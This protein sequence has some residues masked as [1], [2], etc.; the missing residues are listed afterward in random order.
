MLKSLIFPFCIELVSFIPFDAMLRL[1]G[2]LWYYFPPFLSD[3]FS[4][5]HCFHECAYSPIGRNIQNYS[6]FSISFF[7]ARKSNVRS[8][9]TRVKERWAAQSYI[10]SCQWDRYVHSWKHAIHCFCAEAW[11]SA[12]RPLLV[13]WLLTQVNSREQKWQQNLWPHHVCLL[14]LKTLH[15]VTQ[16]NAMSDMA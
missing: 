12:E 3:T 6:N 7:H 2:Q 11:W 1:S 5:Q 10:S 4:A 8:W 9:K 13:L 16:I 14:H 15:T